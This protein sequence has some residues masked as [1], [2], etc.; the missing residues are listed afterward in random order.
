MNNPFRYGD[1]VTGKHFCNRTTEITELQESIKSGQNILIY[2]ERRMG[3][4]SLL[5]EVLQDLREE[6]MNCAYVDLWPTDDRLTFAR[7]LGQAVANELRGPLERILKTLKN[8]FQSF[9]ISSSVNRE[10]EPSFSFD[11]RGDPEDLSIKE[12]MEVP[13]KLSESLDQKVVV[14]FDEIQEIM[15][16]DSDFVERKL[17]SVIQHHTD[18]AYVFLGSRRH[19]VQEMFMDRSSPFYQSTKKITLGTIAVQDWIP[20]IR[21]RFQ[22]GDRSISESKVERLC[23]LTEGHPR[24]TQHLCEALWNVSQS[25]QEI[26]DELINKARKRAIYEDSYAYSVIMENLTNNQKRLL[27]GIAEQGP[28]VSIYS[29][30]FMNQYRLN[31]HS[32]VQVAVKALKKKDLVDQDEEGFLILDRF[33][34]EWITEE[35]VDQ[36]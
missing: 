35:F 7:A 34:K 28:Q 9:R 10:G 27:V 32:S 29:K 21:K 13:A 22:S 12:I 2:S 14:V 33:L 36:T 25:G 24:Y 26:T 18:V 23:E 20:F 16:Y 30:E 5:K 31:G 1:V 19:V 8:W 11:F 17:R 15:N 6:G 3:K 4:T